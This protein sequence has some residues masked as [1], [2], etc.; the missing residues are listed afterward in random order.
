MTGKLKQ[1]ALI[2]TLV[3]S[4]AV[5]VDA[6]IYDGT[7][8]SPRE[9]RMGK[10]AE[11][12]DVKQENNTVEAS[13]PWVD[14]PGIKIKYNLGEI[15]AKERLLDRRNQEALIDNTNF[16]EGGVKF[17]IILNEKPSTNQFCYTVEGAENYIFTYQG[18]LTAKEIADGAI[19]PDN[20]VGSYSVYHKSLKNNQYKTGKAFHI[21]R[22]QVWSLSD[23]TNKQLATISYSE[24][25]LC[26]IA[27]Q[28]FLDTANYPVRIDPTFGYT[29]IGGTTYPGTIGNITGYPMTITNQISKL[30]S[31]HIY[32]YNPDASSGAMALAIYNASTTGFGHYTLATSTQININSAT[33]QW[34]QANIEGTYS[35]ASSTK[36]LGTSFS[37]GDIRW[38]YDSGAFMRYAHYSTSTY[39]YP[40]KPLGSVVF[41]SLTTNPNMYSFYITY[42]ASSSCDNTINIC[43]EKKIWDNARTT[44][45]G[46]AGAKIVTVSNTESYVLFEV[47]Y[48]FGSSLIGPWFYARTDD[49]F[50]TP[51][52]KFGWSD[53]T[54]YFDSIDASL[55][56]S[57]WT[58]AT[59][60]KI[61]FST[62]DS[63]EDDLTYSSYTPSTNLWSGEALATT[64]GASATAGANYSAITMAENGKLFMASADV[65]D[66]WVV[67]CST[68]CTTAGNWSEQGT[69]WQAFQDRGDDVPILFPVGGTNNIML[70]RW[71]VSANQLI[72]NQYSATSSS[73]VN[74]AT[75]TIA[76][77]I[78]D[79]TTYEGQMIS[80][81]YASTTGKAYLAVVDDANDYTTADHDIRVWSYASSTGWVALTNP[82]TTASGGLTGVNISINTNNGYLFCS[83]VRRTTIGTATTGGIYYKMSTDGG[84]TWSAE[85]TIIATGRNYTNFGG[86]PVSNWQQT[87]TYKDATTD[88]LYVNTFWVAS[89]TSSGGGTSAYI[90][91][92]YFLQ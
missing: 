35:V 79:N 29:S 41:G 40:L 91:D 59:S 43:G 3:T 48:R 7:E 92:V 49:N 56:N 19:R 60:T 26:V 53:Y 68:T 17:D 83:Y 85:N 64:Q 1:L 28:A 62:L 67:G 22:P 36:Y 31:I 71:D 57:S 34:W 46:H 30:E 87:V 11:K 80:V 5:S 76:T 81:A 73:W 63:G 86:A 18:E 42:T 39:S 84:S 14:Q 65:S 90:E 23:D 20:I 78:D 61:N 52:W 44:D 47:P 15:T 69:L 24:G 21:E 55:W 75:A 25:Q 10:R 12:I 27:P 72:Y 89:S 2:A 70:V 6:T 77:A 13:L 9:I 16:G 50:S 38:Y 8:L 32:A 37:E 33:P 51:L 45:H 74:T 66:S 88:S 4:G 54:N 82:V 58:I